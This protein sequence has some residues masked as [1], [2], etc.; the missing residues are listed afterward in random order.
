MGQITY[1]YIW[2]EL[3]FRLFVCVSWPAEG[4]N[5]KIVDDV[6]SEEEAIDGASMLVAKSLT[7]CKH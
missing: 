1:M 5:Q 3:V 4:P 2:C 7:I 6:A